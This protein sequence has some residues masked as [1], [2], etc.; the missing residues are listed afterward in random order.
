MGNPIPIGFIG[1]AYCPQSLDDLE[2]NPFTSGGWLITHIS[3]GHWD[4]LFDETIAVAD[5]CIG[6]NSAPDSSTDGITYGLSHNGGT[7]HWTLQTFLDGELADIP[8]YV[9]AFPRR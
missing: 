5:V 3:D 7:D 8:I 1:T 4:I 9:W 6:Y 2:V